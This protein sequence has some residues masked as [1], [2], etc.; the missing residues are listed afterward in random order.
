MNCLMMLAFVNLFT[1]L[2][3]WGGFFFT[4]GGRSKKI[5]RG[6]RDGDIDRLGWIVSFMCFMYA[7]ICTLGT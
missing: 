1:L 4:V 6:K 2:V 7:Y 5:E 3:F